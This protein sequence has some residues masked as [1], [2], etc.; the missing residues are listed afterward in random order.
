MPEESTEPGPD[1]AAERGDPPMNGL[2]YFDLETTGPGDPHPDRDRIVE[3]SFRKPGRD[4]ITCRVNPGDDYLP[5]P[6][7]RTEVHGIATEDV[8][9]L[10]EFER[11]A[12]DV[13][14][15]VDGAVLVGYGSRGYDVP[16][17]DRELRR[18]DESGLRRNDA[19]LIAHPE[20]DLLEAWRRH[21]DR[22]LPTAAARFGGIELGDDA[23]SAAGDAAV[24]PYV[25]DGMVD[26][27]G[28]ETGPDRD[29]DV[30]IE[31][32][33]P[34]GAIDRA[35][36]FR[37][38]DDGRVVFA[39]SK[40]RGEPVAEHPGMLDWMLD[41]DRDFPSETLRVARELRDRVAR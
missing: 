36:C 19:G 32:F 22:K 23:H 28:I 12:A 21:E 8:A 7:R 24:L 13:Q 18:A 29:L 5:I 15:I 9:E 33:A 41:P 11:H 3:F 37:R 26:E 17:L 31:A 34:E 1:A 30:L 25:L 2:V 16:I 4:P 35:G 10:P 38:D 27:F 14:A 20:I 39:F 6:E 40:H